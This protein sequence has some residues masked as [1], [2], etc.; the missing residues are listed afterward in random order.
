MKSIY[1]Q[2]RTYWHKEAI[3]K[4]IKETLSSA[5]FY[6]VFLLIVLIWSLFIGK[7]FQ[8]QSISP[9]EE[10]SLWHR[11]FYS[12]LVFVTFGAFL[13]WIKFYRL[14]HSIFV[15]L[16][17]DWKLYNGIKRAIWALLILAMYFY[18]VPLIVDIL[19]AIISCLYNLL[20]LFLYLFP[21]FGIVLIIFVLIAPIAVT[22]K[23]VPNNS[24]PL[25]D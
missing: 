25:K 1:K 12:A 5:F 24:L 10:P 9:I 23:P 17:G 13:Y 19:N 14:L 3:I 7:S 15:K 16:L 6:L 21:P 11:A 8:W 22:R 4:N 18:V 2:Y 20:G